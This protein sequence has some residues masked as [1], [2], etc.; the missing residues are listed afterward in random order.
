M[1]IYFL[2]SFS[3]LR[4]IKTVSYYVL[5]NS[6]TW[7]VKAN[8]SKLHVEVEQG[9]GLVLQGGRIVDHSVRGAWGVFMDFVRKACEPKGPS[10]RG[11]KL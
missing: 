6:H 4:N 7:I 10:I 1:L 3:I 5:I 9:R 11:V 2:E 8:V